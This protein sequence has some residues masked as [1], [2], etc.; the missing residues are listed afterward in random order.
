METD[1]LIKKLTLRE[2][3][4]LLTGKGVFESQDV[5]RLGITG[6]KMSDGPNGIRDGSPAFCYPSA[7][8]LACSFDRSATER[9]GEVLGEECSD[10]GI[11]LLLGPAQNLKR[12]PLCGRNFEYYSEDPCLSGELTAGFVKGLQKNTGACVKHFAANNQEYKRMTVNN[13]IAEDV[14]AETYLSSFERVVKKSDPDSIMS[15]YNRVNGEYVGE[16]ESVIDGILRDIWGFSGIVISDWGAVDDKIKAVNAGLDMEMPPNPSN[17]EKLIKAVEDGIISEAAVDKCVKRYLKALAKIDGRKR[18]EF[19]VEKAIEV[20]ASVAA[21]SMVLL[22]NNGVLPID[23]SKGQRIGVFGEFAK[24]PRI[25]GGGSAHVIP[26]FVNSP[27]DA[28][29]AEFGAESVAY[30]KAFTL[31]GEMNNDLLLEAVNMAKTCDICVVFAGL[32]EISESEGYD[33]EHISIPQNQIDFIKALKQ[34]NAKTVVVLSNGGTVETEWD[35]CADALIESYLAGSVFA[36]AISSVL[37]GRRLP[38]GRLAETVLHGV[39]DSSAFPYFVANGSTAYYGEGLFVGYKYY[40]AKGVDVKYPFGFGLGYGDIK[41]RSVTLEDGVIAVELEN[42]GRYDDREVIQIY[43]GYKDGGARPEGELKD[44]VKVSVPKGERVKV[45][46]PVL[47]EWF[48]TYDPSVKSLAVCG[49]SY[50]ISVR[51]NAVQKVAFFAQNKQSEHSPVYDRNTEI[52]VLLKTAKGRKTVTEEL[53]PYLCLAIYGNFNAEVNMV[54]GETDSPMFNQIMKNMPLRA[55]CNLTGG[56]FSE[57]YMNEIIL[58]LN[59]EK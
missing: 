50:E 23:K 5:E 53:K 17:T 4:S 8:L 11:K 43:V 15:C 51:R 36:D 25:Q 40:N 56:R 1:K 7:C 58:R 48:K 38:S 45:E 35:D 28:M 46:I 41:Y 33:R 2:K 19:N 26:L 55:L 9:I 49:G 16:N 47:N 3:C 59:A 10:R 31:D 32:P 27:I 42:V 24:Q 39:C 12:S 44:F 54:D 18:V 34:I 22:K 14:F 29:Q 30:S 52:G 37:S 57:E 13:V 20:S 6:F 21:E